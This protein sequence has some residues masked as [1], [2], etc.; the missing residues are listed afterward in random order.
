MKMNPSNYKVLEYS[1]AIPYLKRTYKRLTNENSPAID[2]W[3]FDKNGLPMTETLRLHQFGTF[4]WING[5]CVTKKYNENDDIVGVHIRVDKYD[6]G[7]SHAIS[8][9]KYKKVLYAFNSWG[10]QSKRLDIIV[11][12]H[13][14]EKYGCSRIV[15]YNGPNLQLKDIHGVCM[16]YS[17]NFL[18]EMLL[19]IKEKKTLIFSESFSK[20]VYK[21]LTTRGLCFG[22]TCVNTNNICTQHSKM[23]DNLI[24]KVPIDIEIN[25]MTVTELKLLGRL[26]KMKS[27][28][29]LKKAEVKKKIQDKTKLFIHSN[30]QNINFSQT[31]KV[32][33]TNKVNVTKLTVK[34]LRKHASNHKLKGRSKVIKRNNLIKF[35]KEYK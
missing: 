19:K 23:H 15:Q 25:N 28:S 7:I 9:I 20:F 34:Q 35:I 32:N 4:E 10:N 26:L 17:I 18:I 27:L 29:G 13:L 21:T 12:E 1:D 33:E 22:T 11:F 3:V 30:L 2:V 8:A 31:N 24:R 6:M 14:R 5:K 16:G